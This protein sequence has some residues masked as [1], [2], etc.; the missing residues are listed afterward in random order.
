MRAAALIAALMLTGCS[1]DEAPPHRADWQ[2]AAATH[3]CSVEQTKRVEADTRF[4]NE[5]TSY[6]SSY[7]YGTAI[8]RNCVARQPIAQAPEVTP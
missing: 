4:C 5:N 1:V 6:F 7:C 8:L 3:A 2:D